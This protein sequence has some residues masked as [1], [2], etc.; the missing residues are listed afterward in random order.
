M[1]T[2]GKRIDALEQ[3]AELIADQTPPDLGGRSIEELHR[4]F[5]EVLSRP[6]PVTSPEEQIL[7]FKATLERIRINWDLRHGK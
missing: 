7:R 1:S 2:I 4:K 5:E 6:R 3:A